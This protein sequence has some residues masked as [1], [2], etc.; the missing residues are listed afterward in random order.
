[1]QLISSASRNAFSRDVKPSSAASVFKQYIRKFLE[2]ATARVLHVFF[3]KGILK[4]YAIFT[5]KHLCWS[6]FFLMFQA[7]NFIKKSLQQ[8]YFPVNFAKFFRT[9]FF[10]EHLRWLLLSIHEREI[11][12]VPFYGNVFHRK[13]QIYVMRCAI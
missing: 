13:L 5:G 7:C 1:M 2:A 12:I 6:L 9:H 4:N 11:G 10:R 3:N 8:R